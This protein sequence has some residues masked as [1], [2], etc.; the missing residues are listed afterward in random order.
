MGSV[1]TSKCTTARASKRL[2]EKAA[3]AKILREAKEHQQLVGKVFDN[4]VDMAKLQ[5]GDRVRVKTRSEDGQ[6]VYAPGKLS[7]SK[8]IPA[9]SRNG[10]W[11]PVG[12]VRIFFVEYRLPGVREPLSDM[13]FA[14]EITVIKDEN[15]KITSGGGKARVGKAKVSK[16]KDAKTKQ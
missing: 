7:D 11:K 3:K 6:V 9:P 2:S 10:G 1:K 4:A 12:V 5:P 15:G 14:E 16:T 8:T 13:F